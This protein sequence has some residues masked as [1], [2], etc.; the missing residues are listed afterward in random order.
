M[1]GDLGVHSDEGV[2]STFAFYIKCKRVG[3]PLSSESE[4]HYNYFTQ[5]R[6]NKKSRPSSVSDQQVSMRSLLGSPITSVSPLIGYRI[7]I[8]ED[9]VVN[10][11]I[12]QQRLSTRGCTAYTADDGEQALSFLLQSNLAT[13]APSDAVAVDLVLMVRLQYQ[14]YVSY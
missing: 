10:Q 4:H 6:V 11:K 7:L 9:N 12:M 14:L 1:G 3:E 13:N 2:G 5:S 8:V